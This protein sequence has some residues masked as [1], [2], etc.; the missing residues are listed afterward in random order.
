M[1]KIQIGDILAMSVPERIRL[2][3]DIW[4]SVANVPDNV[5]LSQSDRDE[6]DR[7]LEAHRANP[8]AASP[9]EVVRER[10]TRPK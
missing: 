8:G 6:L 5:P 10:L 9:W 3:Q 2:A 7:R 1:G 4:D